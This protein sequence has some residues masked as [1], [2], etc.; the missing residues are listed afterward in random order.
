V[1]EVEKEEKEKKV[2]Q[3]EGKEKEENKSFPTKFS[4]CEHISTTSIG[5]DA[6]S[7]LPPFRMISTLGTIIILTTPAKSVASSNR[8]KTGFSSGAYLCR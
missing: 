7:A 8:F 5:A 3:E 2:E 6:P 4:N 1:E